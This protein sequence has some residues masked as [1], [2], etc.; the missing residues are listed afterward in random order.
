MEKA[1][2][3][4]LTERVAEESLA[5]GRGLAEAA[6]RA[7]AA[8]GPYTVE[9]VTAG[10]RMAK[11]GWESAEAVRMGMD[12]LSPNGGVGVLHLDKVELSL[13]ETLSLWMERAEFFGDADRE[14]FRTELAAAPET[15]TA[16]ARAL[17]ESRLISAEAGTGRAKPRHGL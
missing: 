5:A 16:G 11:E 10:I 12:E 17:L 7:A 3:N 9:D 8:L 1:R 13:K 4:G 15:L 14:C 2:E 6:A